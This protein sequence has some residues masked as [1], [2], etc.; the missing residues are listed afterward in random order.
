[1]IFL[2]PP[3]L[4]TYLLQKGQFDADLRSLWESIDDFAPLSSLATQQLVTLEE[5]E[6]VA[7]RWEDF[8]SLNVTR[9]IFADSFVGVVELQQKLDGMVRGHLTC[10]YNNRAVS[11]GYSSI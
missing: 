3:P 5:A 2:S 1:M 11:G 10:G 6:S 8:L 7:V 4:H 9:G